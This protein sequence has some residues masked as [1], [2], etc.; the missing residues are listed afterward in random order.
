[1][2][3]RRHSMIQWEIWSNIVLSQ[4][5]N[6]T[7][8]TTIKWNKNIYLYQTKI[9][10]CKLRGCDPVFKMC[11]FPDRTSVTTVDKR[12]S[13]CVCG[14]PM[15]TDQTAAHW[16]LTWP[17]LSVITTDVC[18]NLSNLHTICHLSG[19]LGNISEM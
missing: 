2:P 17:P 4:K 8:A 3:R 1:M 6:E 14:Q 10:I 16:P 15:S 7:A 18:E 5:L 9:S 19:N 13:M 12:P 11:W